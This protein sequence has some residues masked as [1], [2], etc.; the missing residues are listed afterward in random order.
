[1]HINDMQ[2]YGHS[3]ILRTLDGIDA[4]DCETGGVCGVWSI[5]NIIAHLTST[6][7]LLV[8][9]LEQLLEIDGD[10]PHIEALFA[11]GFPV[12]N[13]SQVNLRKDKSYPEQWDEYIQAFERATELLAKMPDDLLRQTG[14]LTW[15]GA[16]YDFE[17]FF[18]YSY[19]A[20]K[21][22]HSGHIALFKDTLTT[23][24]EK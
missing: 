15:Y 12:W 11:Q 22:E 7:W 18:V 10:K 6:E 9:I 3:Y 23:S 21:R 16:E 19:Y 20:H 1:M 24:D 17:D 5:K 13:D 8:E 4:K 14:L 2:K